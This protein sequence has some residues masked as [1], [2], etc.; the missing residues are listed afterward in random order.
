M[1]GLCRVYIKNV[2]GQLQFASDVVLQAT[3]HYLY[4][5]INAIK[6]V[7]YGSWLSQPEGVRSVILEAF[8]KKWLVLSALMISMWQV[9]EQFV[10]QSGAWKLDKVRS[11]TKSVLS[12]C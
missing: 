7:D 8:L 6:W 10:Q 4:T 12:Q 9:T 11:L 2:N 3:R 5:M 1:M